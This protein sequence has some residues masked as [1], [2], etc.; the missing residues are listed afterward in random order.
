[1]KWNSTISFE[2]GKSFWA[3]SIPIYCVVS[4]P[5][6]RYT[7]WL[8]LLFFVLIL[9]LIRKMTK[10]CFIYIWMCWCER[11]IGTSL[12]HAWGWLIRYTYVHIKDRFTEPMRNLRLHFVR[13]HFF[14]L[15]NLPLPK[16][17][18]MPVFVKRQ[19]RV[20]GITRDGLCVCVCALLWLGVQL[21]VQTIYQ[22]DIKW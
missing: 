15:P 8:L 12:P 1:M 16:L 9:K 10:F 11:R 18:L 22:N 21:N 7:L 14:F 19:N 4:P 17:P 13:H 3:S 2:W 6:I 20:H 5:P